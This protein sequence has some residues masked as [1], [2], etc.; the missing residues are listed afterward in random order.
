MSGE[1]IWS[2]ENSGK[3]LGGPL[4]KNPTP[5]LGLD[6]RPF[7]SHSAVFP[8]QSGINDLRASLIPAQQSSF[9]PMLRGLDKT[10]YGVTSFMCIELRTFSQTTC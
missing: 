6:F 3:P 10:L 9:P 8:Q 7:G 5:A 1:A 2:A 4:P